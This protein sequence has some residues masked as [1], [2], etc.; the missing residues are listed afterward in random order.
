[1]RHLGEITGLFVGRIEERWPGKPPSA[2]AKHAVSGSLELNMTGFEEDSQADLAVH[3]GV[4][5]AL[6]HYAAE[7][8]DFWKLEFPELSERFQPGGFGENI[9]TTGITEHDLCIGD[10]IK[11]GNSLVQ[12]SQ[13][14]QPCWKLN[15]HTGNDKLAYRFQKTGR[16]GWYYRVL[17]PG[18]VEL[19]D[20]IILMERPNEMWSL[21]KLIAARFN[22]AISPEDASALAALPQLAQGWRDVFEKK[23]DRSYKEDTSARLIGSKRL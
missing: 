5:K 1:M 10:I 17:E 2:I 22:R 23:T 19:G 14:R 3:G 13:G 18:T 12:I 21:S 20:Q 11:L 6:H 7:H 16:T 4:E 8:Y 15:A 9:S